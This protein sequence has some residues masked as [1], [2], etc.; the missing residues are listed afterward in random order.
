[1]TRWTWIRVGFNTSHRPLQSHRPQCDAMFVPCSF[2]LVLGGL[3]GVEPGV[4]KHLH[5]VSWETCQARIVSGLPSWHFLALFLKQRD[6]RMITHP[7]LTTRP[8]L[9]TQPTH[10][11]ARTH[12]DSRLRVRP[13]VNF[14]AEA[15]VVEQFRF[16][17]SDLA[18]PGTPNPIQQ[19]SPGLRVG[20]G[21]RLGTCL[22]HWMKPKK[23]ELSMWN[24]AKKCQ[25][26]AVTNKQAKLV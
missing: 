7:C 25:A 6:P 2:C 1:M 9:S 13:T 20:L 24:L 5:V 23:L 8:P 11:P 15:S 16:M 18:N 22:I 21:G 17:C 4:K 12:R 10:L 19:G 26:H 14:N 3:G